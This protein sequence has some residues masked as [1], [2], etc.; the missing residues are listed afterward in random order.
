MSTSQ[1]LE[2]SNIVT[3]NGVVFNKALMTS[4]QIESLELEIAVSKFIES[5]NQIT[6][7]PQGFTVYPDGKLP[8]VQNQK[9]RA[10]APPITPSK[11]KHIIEDIDR[12]E[13]TERAKARSIPV[14]KSATKPVKEKKQ[15]PHLP[16]G[17]LE[18]R[19]KVRNAHREAIL[20]GLTEF[21]APCAKHGMTI[22]T[23]YAESRKC[24]KCMA[25]RREK[26]KVTTPKD[27]TR[28]E[29][30][31]IISERRKEAEIKG[32]SE[33]IGACRVH[34][35]TL[36]KIQV[37]GSRCHSCCL[38]RGRRDRNAKRTAEGM[39][40]AQ[41][42]ARNKPRIQ[43][44]VESGTYEFLAECKNCGETMFR[45]KSAKGSTKPESR[46]AF[47]IECTRKQHRKK[48]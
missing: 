26:C 36:F 46:Y 19:T 29:R 31:K 35:E 5:G 28:A 32:L 47:C 7:L 23:A 4:K 17:E 25:E 45:L 22:F 20:N 33:F 43:E 3:F 39:L 44:A 21:E 9:A 13:A 37:N 16:P 34:G 30:S 24:Q 41:R 27:P 15:S 38:E 10:T 1:H 11:T 18:R 40:D 42:K 12:Q 14:S 6:P 8:P 48:N 2:N